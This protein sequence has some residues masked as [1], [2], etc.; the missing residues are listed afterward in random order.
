M[1]VTKA[2][3]HYF[4][5]NNSKKKTTNTPLYIK[6]HPQHVPC[7]KLNIDRFALPMLHNYGIGGVF[8]DS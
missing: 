1:L 6:W 3:E 5:T 4:L 7:Y 2:A 8:R